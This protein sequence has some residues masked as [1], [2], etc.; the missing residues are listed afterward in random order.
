MY[1]WVNDKQLKLWR[2]SYYYSIM[3]HNVEF[4][5]LAAARAD[6]DQII[7]EPINRV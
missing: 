4:I 5:E 7:F 6:L 2:E 3:T 1:S